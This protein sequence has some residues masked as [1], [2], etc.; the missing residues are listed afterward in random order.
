MDQQ[1]AADAGGISK[2]A[3][4]RVEQGKGSSGLTLSAVDRALDWVDNACEDYLED[5][6]E[7]RQRPYPRR[8][9]KDDAV[10]LQ[11]T[12]FDELIDSMQPEEV[13]AMIN[14]WKGLNRPNG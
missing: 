14:M 9:V 11:S 5:G 8:P 4:Q 13:Q 1:Q 6:T 3:W 7:P 2:G 10:T 12:E